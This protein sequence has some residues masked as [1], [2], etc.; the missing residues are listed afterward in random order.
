[1]CEPHLDLLALTPAT[2]QSRRWQR[3]TGQRLGHARISRGILRDGSFGQHCGMSEHT[4]QSSLLARYRSVLPPCTVPRSFRTAFRRGNGRRRWALHIEC[5]RARRCHHPR[6][7]LSNTGICGHDALL[8]HQ[9]VQHR[10]RP[11][12]SIGREP[13]MKPISLMPWRTSAT[14]DAKEAGDAVLSKPTT[15]IRGCCPHAN[16]RSSILMLIPASEARRNKSIASR[17]C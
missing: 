11:I 14:S 5:R 2:A 3:A 7:D 6:F 9:S 17:V 1:V 4:S 10:S 8:L 12:R 16:V 15:G 13:S